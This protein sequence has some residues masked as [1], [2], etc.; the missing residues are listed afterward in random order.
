MEAL[1]HPIL[2]EL[3]TRFIMNE[4]GE[5]EE[6]VFKFSKFQELWVEIE[7]LLTM[8][9]EHETSEDDK[10]ALLVLERAKRF[11]EGKSKGY[12]QEEVEKMFGVS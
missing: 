5:P 3:G 10:I 2:K 7:G 9:E 8:E 12:T 11:S 1:K 6:I 4:K